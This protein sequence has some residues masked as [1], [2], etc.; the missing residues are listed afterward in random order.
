MLPLSIRYSK[1]GT[2][3]RTV[4]LV[5]YILQLCLCLC[6]MCLAVLGMYLGTV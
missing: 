3:E 5:L 6:R 1:Y 4:A 2:V